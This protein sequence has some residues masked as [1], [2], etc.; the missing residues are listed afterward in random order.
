MTKTEQLREHLKDVALM[1]SYDIEE[2]NAGHVTHRPMQGETTE[3]DRVTLVMKTDNLSDKPVE[4]VAKSSFGLLKPYYLDMVSE[5]NI[6][7]MKFPLTHP[8]QII[9]TMF[10]LAEEGATDDAFNMLKV[11]LDGIFEG[12]AAEKEE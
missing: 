11:T 9:L 4:N 8:L 2:L 7:L 3:F 10:I 6:D 1:F 5:R 12:M